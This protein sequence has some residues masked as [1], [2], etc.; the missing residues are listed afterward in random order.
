[1]FDK[2]NFSLII[3]KPQEPLP[4]WVNITLIVCLALWL[5]LGGIFF[6]LTRHI[7]HQKTQKKNLDE[8]LTQ[9]YSPEIKSMEEQINTIGQKIN[10]FATVA[11]EHKNSFRLFE[12]LRYNCHPNV[13]FTSLNA[14]FQE[15]NIILKGQTDTYLSLSQQIDILKKNPVINQVQVSDITLSREG[16]ID[17]QISFNVQ[18]QIFTSPDVS[19]M[20]PLEL[21]LR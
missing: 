19:V 11:R 13:R 16:K 20:P 7:E 9:L 6:F 12:L 21:L 3:P 17:F 5:I 8:Q 14:S 1:M 2:K 18:P 15:G 4:K 10:R